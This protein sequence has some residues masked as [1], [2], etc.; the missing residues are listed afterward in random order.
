M[1]A[2]LVGGPHL[3]LRGTGEEQRCDR[4]GRFRP[5]I[6]DTLPATVAGAAI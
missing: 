6:A 1:H 2:T 4:R 5:S 3:V